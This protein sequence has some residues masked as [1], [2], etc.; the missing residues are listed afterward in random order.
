MSGRR[1]T[2]TFL[3]GL[4]FLAFVSLGLPDGLLGVAWPSMRASF[5]LP[6]DALGALL[7]TT[8][9]GYVAASFAS[10]RL[11][12]RINVGALLAA[13]CLATAVALLG[14][15]T[16]PAWLVIVMLGSLTGL[17]AGAIDAGL[18]TFVATRCSART[19]SLLHAFYGLGTTSGPMIMTATMAAGLSWH[20]GYAIVGGAQLLLA[21]AFAATHRL[22][23]GGS[24]GSAAE[25]APAPAGR[26][27]RLAGTQLGVAAFFLYVGLEATAGA[28]IYS[29]LNQARHVSMAAAGV[30]VSVFWGGLMFG[31]LLFGLAPAS[32]RPESL[33]RPC[34]IATLAGAMILALDLGPAATLLA[35]AILGSGA[36]P[37]FPSLI[38]T[39][40]RRL[41]AAHTANAVGF[42]VAAAALGQ[43]LLPALVGMLA[44]RAGLE[45]VP[46]A[47]ASLSLLLLGIHR[48][49]ESVGAPAE[50]ANA[51]DER[52]T[53]HRTTV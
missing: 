22:W 6:L 34:I 31:R 36:G 37:I 11:L 50:C 27:L 39:T 3:L 8:T 21:T 13:S 4:S 14:Y 30:T 29:L 51:I 43:S 20:S 46:L 47:L 42:Q 2:P 49:L 15:A 12:A 10:G 26:T 52:M 40:P 33:L 7:V 16:A 41:G 23:P 24:P 38:A 5:G 45:V 28:W 9:T 48:L 18:N 35:V 53:G 44:A 32:V 19:L 17:G 25:P 1:A